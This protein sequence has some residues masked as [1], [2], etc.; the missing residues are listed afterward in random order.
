MQIYIFIPYVILF[1]VLHHHMAIADL[2]ILPGKCNFNPCLYM[3][4][5]PG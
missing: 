1:P 2:R 4:A 3:A 5:M